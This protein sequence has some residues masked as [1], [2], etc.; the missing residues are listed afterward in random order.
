MGFGVWGLGFGVWGLG[1]GVWGMGLGVGGLGFGVWG[2]G[3]GVRE[4]GL[5]FGLEVAGWELRFESPGLKVRGVH[6][7][8]EDRDLPVRTRTP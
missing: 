8:K 7:G 1:L 3:F 4:L 2:L 5:G 6:I